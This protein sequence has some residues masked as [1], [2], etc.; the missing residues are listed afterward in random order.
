MAVKQKYITS[1]GM[2]FSTEADATAYA[3]VEALERL[4]SLWQ[5]NLNKK[6]KDLGIIDEGEG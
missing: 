5:D 2:E 3:E 1:D 6:K 4:I